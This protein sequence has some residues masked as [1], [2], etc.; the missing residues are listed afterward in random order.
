MA[1][2]RYELLIQCEQTAA[3]FIV[4]EAEAAGA[5]QLKLPSVNQPL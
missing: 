4:M 2:S 1:S 5:L 3:E